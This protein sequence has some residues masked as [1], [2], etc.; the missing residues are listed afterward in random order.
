[1]ASGEDRS[2]STAIAALLTPTHI[3][4]AN[5]GDSR[6]ILLRANEVVEMSDDHKPYNDGEQRRIEAAGGT[7]TMRRV[8][9]DL[10]VSRALGDFCY[11]HA[12]LPPE[13]QQVSAEPEIRVVARSPGADQFLLLACDGVWDVMTNGEVGSWL[14]HAATEGGLGSPVDLSSSLIDECLARGSRDNMSA[15]VVAFK[16][17]PQPSR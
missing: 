15:V 4:V 7:V 10:A 1:V 6:C 5:C 14:L 17:A 11:K 9:G 13:S 3:I 16:G 2:G 8:N 12:P